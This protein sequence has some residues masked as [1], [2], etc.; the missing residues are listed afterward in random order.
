M[1]KNKLSSLIEATIN[2]MD[3]ASTATPAPF[4]QTRI[5]ERLRAKT[6]EGHSMWEKLSMFLSRP[7]IAIAT[8]AFIILLNI[9]LYNFSDS[10]STL[11]NTLQ[12]LQAS[13]DDNP[14]NNAAALF[15]IENFQ[16]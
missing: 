7:G 3:G 10:H 2:S 6:A 4:L 13:A 12:N 14:M 16:P 5:N 15:D 1:E 9:L 8:L 11:N